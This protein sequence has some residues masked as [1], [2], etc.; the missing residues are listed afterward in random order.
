MSHAHH[1]L[2]ESYLVVPAPGWGWLP[3][4]SPVASGV[5]CFLATTCALMVAAGLL[6]SMASPLL[7][8]VCCYLAAWDQDPGSQL[9]SLILQMGFGNSLL[10]LGG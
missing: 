2:Q 8:V 10:P 6:A 7:L 4:P 3:L 5:L 9:T 1:Y